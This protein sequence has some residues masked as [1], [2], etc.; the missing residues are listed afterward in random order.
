M[1]KAEPSRKTASLYC[2]LYTRGKGYPSRVRA[3]WMY[4]L[5]NAGDGIHIDVHLH[6]ENRSKTTDFDAAR[7]VN[8]LQHSPQNEKSFPVGHFEI[9][10]NCLQF[11]YLPC[12]GSKC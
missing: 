3:G 6:R 7:F 5:I 11:I 9:H 8:I 12:T 1:L 10:G 2:F 4:T